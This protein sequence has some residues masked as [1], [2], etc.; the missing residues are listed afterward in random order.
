MEF[1]GLISTIYP[2]ENNKTKFII[3]NVWSKY[4]YGVIENKILVVMPSNVI[5][6]LKLDTCITV[7]G[8]YEHF[9]NKLPTITIPASITIIPKSNSSD[10]AADSRFVVT[11]FV[12]YS[13]KIYS[14]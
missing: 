7:K 8:I 12:R 1:S 10:K 9:S 11:Y 4:N 5:P 3:T 6:D 13:N 14:F 2:P